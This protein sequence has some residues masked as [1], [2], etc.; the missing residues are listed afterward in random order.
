MTAAGCCCIS[1]EEDERE[2]KAEHIRV[3]RDP[4]RFALAATRRAA[5]RLMGRFFK[6]DFPAS[7]RGAPIS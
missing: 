5:R 2:T 3:H 6:M 1:I 4:R 7:R